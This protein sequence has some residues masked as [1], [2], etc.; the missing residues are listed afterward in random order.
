M[1]LEQRATIPVAREE[2]WD[3]LMDVPQVATCIPGINSVTPE[4]EDKYRGQMKVRVGPISLT[5]Q[6][7]VTL[8]ERDRENWK[9]SLRA[10][11][12]D[13]RIG[14]GINATTH[15]TLIEL[16]PSETELIVQSDA[17]LIG[18][19]GEFGQPLIRK[20]SDEMMQQFIRCVVSKFEK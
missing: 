11:A 9:A 1:N 15:M 10:E 5:F 12:N 8:E 20:K 2:L 7:V 4:G 13:K 6:G 14:G 3:F 19:I 17:R 18:K 16:G